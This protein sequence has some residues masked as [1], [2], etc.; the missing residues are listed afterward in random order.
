[1]AAIP[2]IV[3][4]RMPLVPFDHQSCP[5]LFLQPPWDFGNDRDGVV[6]AHDLAH[7]WA[8]ALATVS[9]TLFTRPPKTGDL[10][11]SRFARRAVNVDATVQPRCRRLRRAWS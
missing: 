2:Y 3:P 1:M 8:T 10:Q 4:K 6:E 5:A 7:A 11:G 9:S